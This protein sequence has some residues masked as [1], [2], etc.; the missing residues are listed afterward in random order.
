MTDTLTVASR[1]LLVWASAT[2]CSSILQVYL[3]KTVVMDADQTGPLVPV[4]GALAAL[5]GTNVNVNVM[6][7]LAQCLTRRAV[8][9]VIEV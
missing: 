5:P 2:G 3:P 6:T 8:K 1:A 9:V 4:P 7:S